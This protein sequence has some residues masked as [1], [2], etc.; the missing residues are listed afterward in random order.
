MKDG[1]K[2]IMGKTIKGVVVK[3][4]IYPRINSGILRHANLSTT[5]LYLGKISNTEAIRVLRK[6]V[7]S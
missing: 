3:E 6:S 4:D 7:K 1:I 2:Q 5:Q